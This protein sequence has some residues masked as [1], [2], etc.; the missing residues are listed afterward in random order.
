MPQN[1]APSPHWT[2]LPVFA[3]HDRHRAGYRYVYPVASR[4]SGGVSI[5]VNLN[6][7]K[8]CNFGCIY[9][10]VNRTAPGGG[11]FID[12]DGLAAELAAVLADAASGVLL[13]APA[14]AALPPAQRHIADIG[15]AGDGEPTTYT[16]FPVVVERIIATKRAAGLPDLPLVLI[17]N[18]SR[19][20][21]TRTQ[22]ALA[23]I[24]TDGGAVWAKLDA[25]T[26]AYYYAINATNVPFTRIL[27][28]LARAGRRFPLV[29]QSCFL[30]VFGVGPDD[31]EIGAYIGRLR[32]LRAAGAQ[33]TGVQVYTVSRPPAERFVSSLTPAE[34]DTIA[35]AVRAAIPALPVETYYGD[36][37]DAS[38]A[39]RSDTSDAGHKEGIRAQ[40]A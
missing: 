9:C 5:G 17:T 37:A 12:L 1:N 2:A 23:R 38:D 26:E 25:G 34:V 39:G 14:F 10:E 13:D 31:A 18:A 24:I 15:I 29:I 28:N 7:D 35:E 20:H 8:V 40:L 22:Q 16:N 33:L 19:F 21:T 6:P 4:R 30:R 11:K 32:D 3:D 36:V 27:D